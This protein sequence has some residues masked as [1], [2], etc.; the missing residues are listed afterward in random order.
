MSFDETQLV[1]L[2]TLDR[3]H[4]LVD[5]DPEDKHI[6]VPCDT[7][8]CNALHNAKRECGDRQG[9][10]AGLVHVNRQYRALHPEQFCPE[11]LCD[12]SGWLPVDPEEHPAGG[13]NPCPCGRAGRG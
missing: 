5:P 11:G 9:D 2:W 3:V 7:E 4:D 12:G 8:W 10:Y 6:G 1:G 13:V